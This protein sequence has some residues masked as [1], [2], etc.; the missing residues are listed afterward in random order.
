MLKNNHFYPIIALIVLILASLA[1]G[2]TMPQNDSE[3]TNPQ[4]AITSPEDGTSFSPGET[5]EVAFAAQY[6]AGLERVELIVNGT[7]SSEMTPSNDADTG[8]IGTLT[9]IPEEEGSYVLTVIAHGK[10]NAISEPVYLNILVETTGLTDLSADDEASTTQEAST[11]PTAAPPTS[12]PSTPATE[13]PCT[14]DADFVADITIPDGSEM[15]PD[16]SFT[17]TWRIRNSGTCDWDGVQLVYSSGPQMGGPNVAPVPDASPGSEV[18]ISINLNAPSDP[19]DH[20]GYWKL[21]SDGSVFGTNLIVVINIPEE[22]EDD[23]FVFELPPLQIDPGIFIALRY[24]ETVTES[25]YIDGGEIGSTTATCPSGSIVT[26]GGFASQDD[27]FMYTSSRNGNGWRVYAKNNGSANRLMRVYAVCMHNTGGSVSQALSSLNV[28]ANSVGYAEASCPAGSIITGGGWAGKSDG[29]LVVYNSSLYSGGW[30][31]Y[32]RNVSGSA[33]QLNAYAICVSGVSGSSTS[34]HQQ[35]TV[36]NGSW[37]H[38]EAT[39]SSG[40]RTGGGFATSADAGVWVYN[41]SPNTSDAA[42]WDI[43]ARNNTGSNV[44]LNSYAICTTFD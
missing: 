19:G 15:E 24:V 39:C 44:L 10:G 25:V 12:D 42:V 18:D 11:Q 34:V 21:R 32:A 38:A 40:L 14:M 33:K 6:E 2:P 35:V 16:S 1:C 30:R 29:S 26:S 8:L 43:Y 22:E 5:V 27:L 36:S 3:A 31:V 20:T 4:V 13:P 23:G 28:P 37:N 17:K 7:K 41:T 9:W